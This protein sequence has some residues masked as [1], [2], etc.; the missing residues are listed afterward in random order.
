M[1][2]RTEKEAAAIERVKRGFQQLRTARS[3]EEVQ[4]AL[5]KIG[6]PEN[7]IP[8]WIGRK[9]TPSAQ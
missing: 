6:V 1:A 2:D 9:R 8:S 3:T 4:K 7:Q 5:Q